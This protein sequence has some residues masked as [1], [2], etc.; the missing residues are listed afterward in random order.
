MQRSIAA[1]SSDL[2]LIATQ[3]DL[4]V[5]PDGN[6]FLIMTVKNAG[7]HNVT[8]SSIAVLNAAGQQLSNKTSLSDNIASGSSATFTVMNI[9]GVVAGGDY[10]VN[11]GVHTINGFRN[12]A[13]SVRAS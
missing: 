5:T 8:V 13:T 3:S 2:N 7:D 12:W 1:Y 10:V 6:A 9:S 4:K 11:L